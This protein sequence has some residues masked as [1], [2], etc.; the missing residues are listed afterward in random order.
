MTDSPAVL[1]RVRDSKH[2]GWLPQDAADVGTGEAR[3]LDNGATTRIQVR[4]DPASR[5]IDEAVFTVSGCRAAIASAS[6]VAE[7]LQ[8]AL[9]DAVRDMDAVTVV[10]ELQLPLERASVAAL[11]VDVARRAIEDWEQKKAVEDSEQ[12]HDS[13]L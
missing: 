7:R 1:E 4:I 12:Q 9:S 10:A 13:D 5:R 2:A 3:F 11:A 8:G 6:L